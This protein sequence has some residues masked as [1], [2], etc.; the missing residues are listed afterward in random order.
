MIDVH[1]VEEL[2]AVMRKR[3]EDREKAERDQAEA[4]E[5]ERRSASKA[6][7]VGCTRRTV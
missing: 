2:Q 3:R 6:I 4:R 1:Q 5:L 7:Q